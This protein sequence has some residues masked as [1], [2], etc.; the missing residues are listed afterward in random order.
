MALLQ[1]PEWKWV[2]TYRDA[3]LEVDDSKL[4]EKMKEAEMAIFSRIKALDGT[5]KSDERR[6]LANAIR[7]L[8]VLR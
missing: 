8:Q 1:H 3:F 4:I 5:A 2:A 7:A 6:A